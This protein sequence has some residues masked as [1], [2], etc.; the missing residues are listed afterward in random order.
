MS[1]CQ[2]KGLGKASIVN[3]LQLHA[4][5]FLVE[6]QEYVNIFTINEL[7]KK[8]PGIKEKMKRGD[9]I[10]NVC[11]SGYRSEGVYFYD[12]ENVISQYH[13]WDDYGSVPI[14]FKV[15][16]EFPLHYW[17]NLYE[18]TLLIN[19]DY[20]PDSQSEF[21][22]HTEDTIVCIDLS[23]MDEVKEPIQ[24]NTY[25]YL[26]TI[27]QITHN[28][29]PYII[30]MNDKHLLNNIKSMLLMINVNTSNGFKDFSKK[31]NVPIENI[32]YNDG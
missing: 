18:N 25:E 19:K 10:E 1:K 6:I 7:E 31:Y 27:I 21:Y 9:I 11:E 32:M 2:H 16:T 26:N 22:W 13:E 29:V 12:G 15:I 14:E 24:D 30:L 5:I 4:N 20:S 23:Q 3:K 8:Y 28:N 17:D